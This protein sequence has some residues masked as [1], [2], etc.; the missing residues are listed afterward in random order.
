MLIKRML[1]IFLLRSNNSIL[2]YPKCTILNI[3]IRSLHVLIILTTFALKH[4]VGI[5]LTF[6][7][8]VINI[9]LSKLQVRKINYIFLQV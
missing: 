6:S 5:S 4:Y 9:S 7:G 1:F 2:I 3:L 8:N